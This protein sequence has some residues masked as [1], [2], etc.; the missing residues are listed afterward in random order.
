M[1]EQGMFQAITHN[2][3]KEARS[4][5]F[6]QERTN[7]ART[8]VGSLPRQG[9]PVNAKNSS[10][11]AHYF[12][13]PGQFIFCCFYYTILFYL[14]LRRGGGH[15]PHD[16]LP[17]VPGYVPSPKCQLTPLA[18]NKCNEI[19]LGVGNVLVRKWHLNYFIYR[20]II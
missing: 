11:L 17:T 5:D 16:P 19:N 13:S 18:M 2:C 4:Q 14:S 20:P 12:L 10:D 3:T 6:V 8:Q 9:T 1:N 7:L 15:G